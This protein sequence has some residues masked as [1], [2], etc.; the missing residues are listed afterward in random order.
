MRHS[1]HRHNLQCSIQYSRIKSGWLV[2]EILWSIL[3]IAPTGA[4][5]GMHVLAATGSWSFGTYQTPCHDWLYVHQSYGKQGE[6][7][8]YHEWARASDINWIRVLTHLMNT[9]RD[10]YRVRVTVFPPNNN[11]RTC[12]LMFVLVLRLSSISLITSLQGTAVW[13]FPAV[14]CLYELMIGI[15]HIYTANMIS[16]LSCR[17]T[18]RNKGV[19]KDK[20]QIVA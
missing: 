18:G 11:E 13:P 20:R 3:L 9:N 8:L 14:F 7:Q 19:K 1:L 12:S 2:R 5:W 17:A 10:C 15:C 6:Y 16:A 4:I